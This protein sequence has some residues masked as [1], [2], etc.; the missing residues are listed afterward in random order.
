[1]P[2]EAAFD[3]IV[4]AEHVRVPSGEALDGVPVQRVVRPA[5]VDEVAACLTL[6]RLT[7]L[8]GTCQE[9]GYSRTSC[10]QM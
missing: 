7:C 8:Y 9:H 3:R 2:A 4:G 1:M 6:A 10:C 5:N